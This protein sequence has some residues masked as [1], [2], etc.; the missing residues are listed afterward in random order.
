MDVEVFGFFGLENFS[1]MSFKVALSLPFHNTLVLSKWMEI[2]YSIQWF[3]DLSNRAL[4][5][6]VIHCK[7]VCIPIDIIIPQR[8]T[9][10]CTVTDWV[11][12]SSTK[13]FCICV[14]GVFLFPFPQICASV[15]I[16]IQYWINSERLCLT[17]NT[18]NTAT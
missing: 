8:G 16:I 18:T 4:N 10:I 3:G 9:S 12:L 13:H 1:E 15:Y 7:S 14:V 6:I 5:S 11:A 17:F 2:D